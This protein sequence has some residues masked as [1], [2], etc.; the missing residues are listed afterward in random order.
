[1]FQYVSFFVFCILFQI[2]HVYCWSVVGV[3]LDFLNW[4]TR[5]LQQQQLHLMRY[6]FRSFSFILNTTIVYVLHA[7]SRFSISNLQGCFLLSVLFIF[8][9]FEWICGSPVCTYIFWMNRLF[10]AFHSDPMLIIV[11][12]FV[13]F[14]Y[15]FAQ[16]WYIFVIYVS[17]F[18]D[19]P[20]IGNL[21]NWYSVTEC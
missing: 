16:M 19:D 10:L 17:R 3:P 20:V 5:L 6:L 7:H 18:T 12:V 2:T 14:P 11:S 13:T 15:K 8:V 9:Q 21:E 4:H 1:M